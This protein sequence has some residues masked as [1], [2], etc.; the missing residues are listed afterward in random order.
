VTAWP[1]A[2]E[3]RLEGVVEGLFGLGV[4]AVALASGAEYLWLAGVVI[5][6]LLGAM[7]WRVRGEARALAEA[8]PL[9][10]D[11]RA[12]S[13][14]QFTRR[15]PLV[16]ASAM[17]TAGLGFLHPDFFSLSV[18]LLLSGAVLAFVRAVAIG[19]WERAHG[20]RIVRVSGDTFASSEQYFVAPH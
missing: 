6:V 3:L 12:A 7:A 10:E 8:A 13:R 17:C 19:R 5:A 11:T 20:G 9:P 15:L 4:L 16:V 2:K 18:A 14:W 1:A